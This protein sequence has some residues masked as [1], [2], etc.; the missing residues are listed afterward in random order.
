MNFKTV[1]YNDPLLI[2]FCSLVHNTETDKEFKKWFTDDRLSRLFYNI[3]LCLIDGSP[4]SF[5]GCSI[6]DSK[7]RVAQQHYT[8]LEYRK[9]FRDLLIRKNGFMDRHIKTA[10]SLNLSTI[11]I[12]MHS[13]N[14]KTDT[15]VKIYDKKRKYYRHL[16]DLKY[17]G[18][19]KINAVNQHCYE[20]KI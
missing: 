1:V 14:K 7:L 20:K 11:L 9:N 15:V 8:L 5:S 6:L 12:T 3:E 17:I 4:I 10:K 2:K 19:H 16:K 18:L 13:F